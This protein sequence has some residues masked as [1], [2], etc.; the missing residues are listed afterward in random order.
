MGLVSGLRWLRGIV[1][2]RGFD[3]LFL[4]FDDFDLHAEFEVQQVVCGGVLGFGLRGGVV[5][6]FV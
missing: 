1:G 6:G 2:G 3:D 5:G 4:F